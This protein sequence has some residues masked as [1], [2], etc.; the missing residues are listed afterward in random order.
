MIKTG[1]GRY[2]LRVKFMALISLLLIVS[3]TTLGWYFI[4]RMRASLQEELQKRGQAL[5]KNLAYNSTYGVT[6]EDTGILDRFLRGIAEESDIAYVMVLNRQG[7]ALAHSNPQEAGKLLSDGITQKVLASSKSLVQE[8]ST[9]TDALYDISSPVAAQGIVTKNDGSL[10]DENRVGAVRIGMSLQGLQKQISQLVGAG[11][12]I[13]ALIIGLGIVV[14]MFFIQWI[15]RP[16]EYM[17]SAAVKMADG[18]FTQV[19]RVDSQ[20][21]VG[22]LG[23]TFGIMTDNL[24]AMIR[25]V[26]EVADSVA[27]A[28]GLLNAGSRKMYDGAQI[29]ANATE[30]AA[31]SVEELNASIRQIGESIE[32]LSSSAEESSS[33]ILEMSSSVSEVANNAAGLSSSVEDTSSSIIEMNATIKEVADNVTLLS[34]AS[35]DT[36][37]AVNEINT[38]V[39]EVENHSRDAASLSERVTRDAQEIGM[40]SIEKTI[41]AMNRI[42]ET[43]IKSADVINRLGERSEQ[44]GR[45]LTVIDEVT[46]QTNLLALNAAILAAQAGEQGKGFAVVADEI[47]NLADRTG[48]STKEI[49]ELIVNVQTESKDAVESVRQGAK[50]VEEGVGL[51]I[52]ARE[53]LQKILTTATQSTQMSKEIERATVEQTKGIRQV[54]E[55][56]QRVSTMAQQIN[57]AIHEHSRGSEQIMHASERMRD[58]TRQVKMST[59]EQA[60]GSRQITEAVENVTER[61]QQIAKAM[62]EQ[63]RGNEIIT[64]A[65]EDVRKSSQDGLKVVAEMNKT[66]EDLTQ[67]ADHLKQSIGRFKVKR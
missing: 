2:G 5:A 66:V 56:M 45:I 11:L 40:R 42:Q 3:G 60:K 44:I 32:I 65:V 53:A 16:I 57:K 61:V 63:K 51:S 41:S 27:L 48:S 31:S 12:L 43:V 67:Q 15:V 55:A 52:E 37:S 14:S 23:N 58:M 38:T 28:A 20:D 54:T 29:Q 59:E 21:E 62:G 46:K 17:A 25:Q 10:S 19:I 30:A 64:R 33:S 39:R 8:H 9:G 18:D 4:S 1:G 7:V 6:I 49:S 24:S 13:T 34:S 22:V 47:K 36:V 50:S 35:D 26:Q